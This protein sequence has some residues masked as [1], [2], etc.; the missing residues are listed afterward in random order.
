MFVNS[1]GYRLNNVISMSVQLN[2]MLLNILLKRKKINKQ[3]IIIKNTLKKKKNQRALCEV[4]MIL[5]YAILILYFY[6]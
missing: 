3:N 4:R 6:A 1:K 5:N 2:F